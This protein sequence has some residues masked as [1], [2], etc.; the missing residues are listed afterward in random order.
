M[1]FGQR[2]IEA[3][4]NKKMN[5][6]QLAEALGIT[7]TRLNYWEK[8]K[9]QPDVSM[10]QAL[11]ETLEVSADYLI[12]NTANKKSPALSSEALKLAK[13]FDA[14]DQHGQRVVRVVTDEELSRLAAEAAEP[15]VAPLKKT[16]PLFGNAFA[17]GPGEPDF[18]N[19]PETYEI[20]G[21]SPAQFAIRVTG[22]SMEP[23]LHDQSVALGAF[24]I[25]A[26]GDVG[27]F[28]LDGSYLVK[29]DFKDALGNVYLLS[30]N[31]SE[32]DKDVTVWA[33]GNETLLTIGTILMERRPPLPR[34]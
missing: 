4:E 3:R 33:S 13:D 24:G 14:L 34:I 21:A 11:A 27:A 29:Q 30:L 10:I 31:R 26:I 9:R 8:D 22:T 20:D 12:G 19:P 7:P 16:V 23:Y 28:I 2:L 18:G 15:D 17:A 25:P 5:Q 32:S 6:K 1:T